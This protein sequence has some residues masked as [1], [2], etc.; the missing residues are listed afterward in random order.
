M[1]SLGLPHIHGV[2]WIDPEWLSE[3]G[4]FGKLADQPEKTAELADI[5]VSCSVTTDDEKLNDNVKLVQKHSHSKSCRKYGTSCR[6]GFPKLPSKYSMIAK[7][8]DSDMDPDTRKATEKKVENIL[9][10]AKEFLETDD[11]REDMSID[12]FIK[13]LGVTDAEYH[14]AVGTMQ[15]GSQLVLKRQVSERFI[16]YYN[17]EVQKA[18]KANTDFQL[19][20]DTYSIVTYMISYVGKDDTGM[21]KFLQEALNANLSAPLEEKLRAIKLAYL[22]NKQM[23]ASEAVYRVLP[24]LHM[25]Q[26]NI[27]TEFIQT[28]FK[29]NR[30]VKYNCIDPEGNSPHEE[31]SVNDEGNDEEI[32]QQG[33]TVH[34][35]GKAGKYKQSRPV[36]DRY[37]QRPDCVEE[38]CLAQFASHY[39]FAG[40]RVP[41]SA[42]FDDS[43]ASQ[44]TSNDKVIFFIL[45]AIFFI[46]MT[47]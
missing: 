29:E 35:A 31:S 46:C 13:V 25:K 15:K 11:I 7:P 26:S 38:M 1:C 9:T 6:F 37:Q 47:F 28:G 32:D 19:A 18:W 23:S 36:H 43:G 17:P 5:L 20:F 34:I 8:L 45:L 10:S 21:T 39:T 44:E 16:N 14:Q 12:E 40:K 4:I 30:S 22:K 2:A 3:F 24:S 42:V 33:E 41:E 27:A